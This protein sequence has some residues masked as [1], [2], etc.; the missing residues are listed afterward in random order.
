[1]FCILDDVW[2][3]EVAEQ[4]LVHCV[5]VKSLK[6]T[7]LHLCDRQACWGRRQLRTKN[8]IMLLSAFNRI[9]I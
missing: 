2:I 1:M 5:R 4:S 7:D 9:H 3:S 6:L 8:K